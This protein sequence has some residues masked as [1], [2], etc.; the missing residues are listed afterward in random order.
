MKSTHF[1]HERWK[2]YTYS[3]SMEEYNWVKIKRMLLSEVIT[4]MYR[5]TLTILDK[6]LLNPQNIR[7]C[8]KENAAYQY[9]T[10]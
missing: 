1:C 7:V 4:C 10:M 2:F 3:K 8:G 6:A 5:C 9:M